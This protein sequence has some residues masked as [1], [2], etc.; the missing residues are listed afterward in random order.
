MVAS[1]ER[2]STLYPFT[3]SPLHLFTCHSP[4]HRNDFHLR[5]DP[6]HHALD[7]GQRAGDGAGAASAG[8]LVVDL[9]HVAL[10]ADD[11]QVAAVTLQIG[12]DFLVQHLLDDGELLL[13][14]GRHL[15]PDVGA[16][17]T[18]PRSR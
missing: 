9:E 17:S 4:S 1:I 3:C 2:V 11:V 13:L 8:A 5:I 10:E 15:A 12:P 18:C 14:L 7:P 16:P 6:P